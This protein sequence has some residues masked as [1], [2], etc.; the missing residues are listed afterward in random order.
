METT[1]KKTVHWYGVQRGRKIGVFSTWQECRE[2]V[3]GFPG[4][5]F[6]KFN[7]KSEA[8]WFSEG[9]ITSVD[10]SLERLYGPL[11]TESERFDQVL[12]NAVKAKEPAVPEKRT[13]KG[14]KETV[15]AWVCGCPDRLGS[16]S[17]WFGKDDSRN[18]TGIYPWGKPVDKTR[19]GIAACIRAISIVA[20][21]TKNSGKPLESIRLVL[22]TDTKYLCRVVDRWLTAWSKNRT[23]VTVEDRNKDLF[24]FMFR[25]LCETGMSIVMVLE[26][27]S[28][29]DNLAGCISMAYDFCPKKIGVSGTPFNVL[30]IEK[31]VNPQ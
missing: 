24:H 1:K 8:E 18:Y 2:S 26:D 29:S 10:P 30:P 27:P 16:V 6:R 7:D 28:R 17:V 12:K 11:Y 22:H 9:R 21:Q 20:H 4:A 31:R 15:N 14:E 19:T 3:A 13:E 23:N 5:V 25:Q